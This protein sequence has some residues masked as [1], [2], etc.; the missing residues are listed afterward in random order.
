MQIALKT[1]ISDKQNQS[2]IDALQKA[3]Q[4]K[5]RLK[6]AN[7]MNKMKVERAKHQAISFE[8]NFE[9]INF[10]YGNQQVGLNEEPRSGSDGEYQNDA[11]DEEYDVGDCD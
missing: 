1:V 6:I 10:E 7:M 3:A 11:P 9:Q 8:R 2:G 4:L 5:S